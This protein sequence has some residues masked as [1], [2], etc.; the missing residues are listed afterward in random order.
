M[1]STMLNASPMPGSHTGSAI[2]M[3]CTK[4]LDMWG[5]EKDQLHCFVV[6][7]AGSTKKAVVDGRY[8]HVSC[9][10]HTLTVGC[11]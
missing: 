7:N 8:T 3:K 5:I 9:S 4:M 11:K 10:A 2:R 1:K 6:G